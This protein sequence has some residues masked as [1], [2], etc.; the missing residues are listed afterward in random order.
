MEIKAHKIK[1][2]E[3]QASLIWEKVLQIAPYMANDN[4]Y[5]PVSWTQNFFHLKQR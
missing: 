5:S 2:A 3:T 4:I 1:I